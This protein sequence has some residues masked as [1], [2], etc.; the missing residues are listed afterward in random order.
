MVIRQQKKEQTPL[1][2]SQNPDLKYLDAVVKNKE[3][4]SALKDNVSLIQ[5]YEISQPKDKTFEQNLLEA[6]RALQKAQ[7]YLTEGF[8]GKDESLLKQA[9]TVA[10]IAED[11]Y[12]SMEKKWR[13]LQGHVE[14]KRRLF[15]EE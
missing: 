1:I 10:E 11:L 4:I 12:D 7:S 6:K 15:S 14:K 8:D 3:A 13:S 2:Q 9:S 5:A